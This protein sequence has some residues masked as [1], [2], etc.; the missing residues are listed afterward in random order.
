ML[1]QDNPDIETIVRSKMDEKVIAAI[2]PYRGKIRRMTVIQEIKNKNG[3][4]RMHD[5]F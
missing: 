4:V 2:L 3:G 1:P 5:Q